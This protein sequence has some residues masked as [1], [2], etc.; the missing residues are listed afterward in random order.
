MTPN[1]SHPMSASPLLLDS[2]AF[3]RV[4]IVASEKPDSEAITQLRIALD[5]SQHTTVPNQFLVELVVYLLPDNTGKMTSYTGQVSLE[6]TFRV[7]KEVADWTAQEIAIVNGAAMLFSAARE[8]VSNITGRGPWPPI[9]LTM[10]S[11]REMAKELQS[12]Q[13]LAES[14]GPKSSPPADL[15]AAR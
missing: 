10:L 14:D 12:Q 15:S 2:Y 13:S 4:E 8:M 3:K 9:T 6:G 7:V 1:G 11:F 5:C